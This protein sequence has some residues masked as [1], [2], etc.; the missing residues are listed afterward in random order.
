MH[1]VRR[2]GHYSA[3][4][5][6]C[7]PPFAGQ[8]NKVRISFKLPYRYGNGW[9]WCVWLHPTLAVN[10]PQRQTHLCTMS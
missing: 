2:S 8:A 6:L 3:L 10:L 5:V 7:C 9:I 1:G 4:S